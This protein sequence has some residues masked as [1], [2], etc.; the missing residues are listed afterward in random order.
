MNKKLLFLTAVFAS[1]SFLFAPAAHAAGLEVTWENNGGHSYFHG[2]VAQVTVTVTN[3][4]SVTKKVLFEQQWFS[5]DSGEA[6][7]CFDRGHGSNENITLEAGKS[8]T[9]TLTQNTPNATCGSAQV[10]AY[11]SDITTGVKLDRKGPFWGLG[12]TGNTCK[13]NFP[14]CPP[15]SKVMVGKTKPQLGTPQPIKL[16]GVDKFPDV[17]YATGSHQIVEH[18]LEMGADYV[19]YL[20]GDK[21]PQ[22][23]VLQCFYHQ[24]PLRKDWQTNWMVKTGP[25]LP[26]WTLESNGGDWGLLSGVAY[27]ANTFQIN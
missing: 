16:N 19:Y 13:L 8:F 2:N 14:A 10:D 11:V 7:S 23:N 5:C 22:T 3:T 27:L 17:G 4:T 9:R 18:R 21:G 15:R 25:V 20:G 26:G 6:K 1:F 24:N 12:Y